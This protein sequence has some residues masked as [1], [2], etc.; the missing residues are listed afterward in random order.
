MRSP[1]LVVIAAWHSLFK[2]HKSTEALDGWRAI[3][4]LLLFIFHA[5]Y[6]V[7]EIIP[8]KLFATFYENTPWLMRWVWG[9]DRGVDIFFVLSGFLVAAMLM[10]DQCE[11]Q[12]RAFYWRR[13]L[14]LLPVYYV[15]LLV[16]GLLSGPN[17]HSLWANVLFVNNY[18]PYEQGA[19]L[20]SWSLAVEVQFYLLAPWLVGLAQ[21][22]KRPLVAYVGLLAIACLWRAWVI[23]HDAILL[24]AQP[25]QFLLDRYV[26]E[27][28]FA[29]AYD[30]FGMRFGSLMI[31][32]IAA[33][34]Y[35]RHHQQLLDL[36]G[37]RFISASLIASSIGLVGLLLFLPG[38]VYHKTFAAP[39]ALQFVY[40]VTH[41][42]LF[43]LAVMA[44][45][46]YSIL[47]MGGVFRWLLAWLRMPLWRPIARLS[48][49]AYLVHIVIIFAVFK[50]NIDSAHHAELVTGGYWLNFVGCAL[51]AL[52]ATWVI[53][54]VLYI[55]VEYP[56]MRLRRGGTQ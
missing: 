55:F 45:M 36:A 14:R 24:G 43:S 37:R 11:G 12:W 42:Y 20:W 28:F 44:L 34:L 26:F 50:A 35:C 46:L 33:H 8:F 48:Y 47:P 51:L 23:G 39:D 38:W 30:N 17:A 2:P 18:L 13:L 49:S 31:G 32:V 40:L 5:F 7:Q 19:M 53:A 21:L 27:Y 9:G 4:M 56:F 15:M 54:L 3:A 16:Y 6:T 1:F 22:L 10:R 41:R 29:N 25:W 52:V